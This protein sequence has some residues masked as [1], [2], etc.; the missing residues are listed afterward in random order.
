MR[1]LKY[2]YLARL[3][4]VGEDPGWYVHDISALVDHDTI[5]NTDRQRWPPLPP[6]ND[7]QISA[8]VRYPHRRNGYKHL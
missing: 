3:L 2:T 1:T 7:T 6:Y 8:I 5:R 4:M